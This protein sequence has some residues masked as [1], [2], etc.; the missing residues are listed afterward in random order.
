[1]SE[2]SAAYA[3]EHLDELLSEVL[4]D[5]EVVIVRREDGSEVALIAADELR[6]IQETLYVL[7]SRTNARRLFDALDRVDRGEGEEVTIEELAA[8]V[9]LTY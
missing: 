3:R 7:S 9:G 8:K 1:M 6:S 5:C 2:K 4:D